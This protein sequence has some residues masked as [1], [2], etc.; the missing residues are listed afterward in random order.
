M[1]MFDEAFAEDCQEDL[2]AEFGTEVE[3]WPDRDHTEK[4]T[5]VVL[6]DRT[7]EAGKQYGDGHDGIDRY[8]HAV[9]G[10][11]NVTLPLD[12]TITIKDRMKLPDGVANVVRK[13]SSGA[14][15]VW[16]VYLPRGVDTRRI[17]VRP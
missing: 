2:L 5:A 12:V 15:Q 8:G 9:P 13:V 7:D 3:I 10:Y 17:R 4:F 6:I 1:S 16:A 14:M 11:Y